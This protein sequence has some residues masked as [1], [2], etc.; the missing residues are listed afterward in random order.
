MSS[1]RFQQSLGNRQKFAV[2]VEFTCPAGGRPD[3]VLKFLSEYEK[4]QPAWPDTEFAALTVT[5][6]PSGVVTALPS[7]VFA[8]VRAGGGMRGLPFIPHISAKGMNRAEIESFLRGLASQGVRDCFVITGDKP[9]VGKGVFELD[10]LN[11]LRLILKMN[12]DARVASGTDEPAFDMFAGAG[13]GLAKYEEGTCYQQMIKVEKKVRHGG[14]GFIISNLIYDPR[15]VEDFFRYLRARELDV[16]VIGNVFFLT[17]PAARRMRHEKLPGCYVSESLYKR[18]AG[19]S[20]DKWIG[21]C[22]QLVAMWRGL[23]ADGVDLGNVEEIGLAREI[24]NRSLAIGDQWRDHIDNIAFPPERPD[25]FY[26][27]DKEGRPT[28]LRQPRIPLRRRILHRTHNRL[29]EP[30]TLGYKLMSGLCRRSRAIRE[31]K[32]FMYKTLYLYETLMKKAFVDCES[33]GDCHLP[34][35]FF[36]CTMGECTK[37]L[38]NAPCADSTADGMCGVDNTVPCAGRQVYDSAR[39]FTGDIEILR[40]RV[41]APKTPDLAQTSS[42]RNFYLHLDHS[43]RNPLTIVGEL[44]HTTIPKVKKAFDAIKDGGATFAPDNPG[45]QF[46]RAAVESQIL[47]GA[48]YLDCNV[49]DAGGGDSDLASRLM[50]GAV[51]QIVRYGRGV[52]PCV[53]SSDV[54]VLK[55]GLKEYFRIAPAGAPMPLVNSANKENIAAFW[56][57]DHAG[58]FKVVYMLMESSLSAKALGQYVKPD[59]MHDSA[60]AFFRQAREHGFRPED[61]FFDTTVM[62]LAVEFSCFDRPGYNYCSFEALRLIMANEEMRGVGT[63]LGI[64][65]LTRDFPSGRKIGVLRAYVHLAM[66]RGLT[67]AIVDVE[68]DFGLKPPED[69]EIV[70]IVNAFITHDG[71]SE[72]YQRMQEAYGRYR[73]FAGAKV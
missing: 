49:D 50:R 25:L 46:V 12:A 19:E 13:V 62:P 70:D 24:V 34:E 47:K 64:S 71:S 7:D 32:G 44:I 10:S 35:N 45:V 31:G 63:I 54:Q 41:N 69:E 65:N 59:E 2:L 22:A 3:R 28:P 58:R 23:G 26:V 29:F 1:S 6:N 51:G 9:L 27:Y 11:L 14:A 38:T 18:V 16:P 30:A 8:H 68:K 39:Y 36:V 21:R 67:A 52:P 5:H 60:V 40:D 42:F 72:A 37:G 4:Q 33:C 73:S 20:R 66:Q 43:Q 53:D 55:A 61:I 17:E 57:L 56:D 48:Q 15:K